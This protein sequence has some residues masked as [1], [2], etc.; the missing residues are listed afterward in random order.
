MVLKAFSVRDVKAEAYMPPFFMSTTSMALRAF[1]DAVGDGKSQFCRHPEDFFLFH[2][3]DFDEQSGLL[4]PVAT[5]L[6]LACASE[7]VTLGKRV[8]VSNGVSKLEGIPSGEVQ[9]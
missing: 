8:D 1:A 5:P 3:G 2:I 4:S 7:F 9:K 6:F